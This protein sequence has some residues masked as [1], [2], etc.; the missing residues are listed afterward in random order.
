MRHMYNI[1]AVSAALAA[2]AAA[3]YGIYRQNKR[4]A[5]SLS[6]DLLLKMDDRFNSP[7]L[8]NYRKHAAES[9]LAGKPTDAVDEVLDFFETI[10]LLVRKGAIEKEMTW[11]TFFYWI[12]RYEH[13][14]R[15]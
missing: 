8:T 12:L 1:L 9:L 13:A 5:L 10:G 6:I 14:T 11:S 15:A 2:A 7:L 4:A 3:W